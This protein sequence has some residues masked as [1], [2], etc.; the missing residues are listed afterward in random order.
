MD[1]RR[2]IVFLFT[3]M[4]CLPTRGQ[5]VID[6]TQAV[7]LDS[8]AVVTAHK[9]NDGKKGD[10]IKGL[11]IEMQ[12]LITFPKVLGTSDP[13]RFVQTLPGVTTN[14]DY[15]CGIRIQGCEASQSIIKLCD[16]PV[17]GQ[18]HILGLFSIFNPGHFKS[19]K[20]STSSQERRI[21]GELNMETTDTLFRSVHGEANLGPVSTHASIGF[22][23]GKKATMMVSGRRSFVDIFYKNLFEMD[24]AAMNYSFYDLNASLLYA[25]DRYNKLDINAYYGKDDGSVGIDGAN[26]GMGAI[27]GNAVANLRWRHSKNGLKSSTQLYASYYF[28][29]GDLSILQSMGRGEDDIL[30]AGIKTI[31]D[32]RGWTFGIEA[33]YYNYQPQNMYDNSGVALQNQIIPRQ[34]AALGTVRL[35]KRFTPGNWAITPALAGSVYA[36]FGGIGQNTRNIFPRV[37]PELKVEYNM[38]HNGKIILETGLKH[39]YL[40]MTGLTNSGFPVEFWLGS[41]R[42]SDP[43]ASLFG[44]LSYSVNIWHDMFGLNVQAYGK[45]LWNQVEYSGFLSEIASGNYNLDSMLLHGDGYNYGASVQ[46]EKKSGKL[47]GWLSYSWGRAL[48]EFDSSEHKG[49]YSSSHERIHEL[50][51][52]ASYKL[53]KWDFGTNFI[54]ASGMPYTPI[55][56]AFYMNEVL[57]VK[58]GEYNSKRLSPYIRLDLSVGYNI[59]TKG[60]FRDGINISVQ[61][62]TARKNQMMA[63]LKIKDGQYK[64][65]PVVLLIP[66]LPSINYYCNF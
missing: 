30:D 45:R 43:Q 59:R 48:R 50:N 54:F 25:P 23:L 3:A 57:M 33:D 40:F 15:E 37:D 5:M 29:S 4:L 58:Y 46:F 66:V 21:G 42:Y 55:T 1:A 44:T 17:F 61:N 27:W 52:V 34:Q 22:P 28:M 24:G 26:S 60:R 51:C 65:A 62:A 13:L 19:M 38:Y 12:T 35:N 36:D 39:Q 32:W 11:D 10:I 41:G 49:I 56:S 31:I 16:V 6:T 9:R 18:G 63:T 20:F 14:S 64:F 8:S 2:I 47:T 53:K 7:K